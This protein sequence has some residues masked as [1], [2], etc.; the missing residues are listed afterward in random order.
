MFSFK[1]LFST[2]KE[3][4]RG[5]VVFGEGAV[6]KKEEHAYHPDT[7]IFFQN[8]GYVDGRVLE[9]DCER[10]LKPYFD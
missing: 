4:S 7:V 9:E 8:M 3:G 10:R 2:T 5:I 1:A 6:F